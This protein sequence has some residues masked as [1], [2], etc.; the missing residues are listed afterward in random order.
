MYKLSDVLFR[1]FLWLVIGGC[2][3]H[4]HYLS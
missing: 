1:F 2:L 3:E 4:L